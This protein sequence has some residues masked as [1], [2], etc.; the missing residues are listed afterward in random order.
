[1]RIAIPG[2][3]FFPNYSQALAQKKPVSSHDESADRTQTSA[4]SMV[5]ADSISNSVKLVPDIS[6][7]TNKADLPTPVPENKTVILNPLNPTKVNFSSS[8]T[9]LTSP[10]TKTTTTSSEY[11]SLTNAGRKSVLGLM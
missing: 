4:D 11:V 6:V 8:L 1:M 7:D 2:A 3:E 9:E 5:S 10:S